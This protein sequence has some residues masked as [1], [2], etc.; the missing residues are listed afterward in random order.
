MRCA[1]IARMTISEPVAESIMAV[2]IE[3][4]G[5]PHRDDQSG[6]TVIKAFYR[7]MHDAFAASSIPW[8][9]C[10]REDRGDG[11]I[12]FV[13]ARFA[14]VRLVDPL[15]GWLSTALT[16]HNRSAALQARLRLRLALHH[17]IVLPTGHSHTGN[18]VVLTCRLLDSA[19]L[20]TALAHSSGNLAVIVSEHIHDNLIRHGHGR[21]DPTAY[22]PVTIAVKRTRARAWV[23]L[24]G[25]TQAPVLDEELSSSTEHPAGGL[26]ITGTAHGTRSTGVKIGKLEWK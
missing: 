7:L 17:G 15:L 8:D 19:P 4:F 9:E 5:D 25:S 20:R 11:A 10:R 6:R 2:D 12:I 22:H 24:P 13:P 16:A 21:I 14:T 1:I 3:R 18:N 26:R 23:H